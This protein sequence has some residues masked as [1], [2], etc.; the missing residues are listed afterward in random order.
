MRTYPTNSPEAAG[1]LLAL[2]ILSDGNVAPT[3]LD[4]LYGSR[5]LEHVALEEHQFKEVLHDLCNDLLATTR[6]GM[7]QV[8]VELIDHLLGEIEAPDL[9]RKLLQAMWRIADADGWL[10]D[11]EAVLLNRAA[12]AWGAETSFATP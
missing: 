7:A 11:A 3:E 9:R 10:A 1:R 2:I 5:I 12:I 6:H 8:D 4:A